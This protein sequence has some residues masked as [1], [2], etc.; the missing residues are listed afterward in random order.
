[1]CVHGTST[2]VTHFHKSYFRDIRRAFGWVIKRTQR[3]GLFLNLQAAGFQQYQNHLFSLALT[4]QV[5]PGDNVE[6]TKWHQH[7]HR[8]WSYELFAA[9]YQEYAYIAEWWR[10]Y[11]AK[12]VRSIIVKLVCLVCF[13]QLPEASKNGLCHRGFLIGKSLCRWQGSV[14]AWYL[15]TRKEIDFMWISE[16]H[17]SHSIMSRAGEKC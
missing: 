7:S 2:L 14:E 15:S 12:I 10:Q 6:T 11:T 3:S 5:G 9:Y 13:K 4:F 16:W 8:W 17:T 1:M